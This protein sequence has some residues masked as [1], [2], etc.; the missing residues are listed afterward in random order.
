[1]PTPRTKTYPWGPGSG[2]PDILVSHPFRKEREKDGAP[3]IVVSDNAKERH[4]ARDEGANDLQAG[5]TAGRLLGAAADG[6]LHGDDLD[7]DVADFG[8]ESV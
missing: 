8:E 7:G 2:A 4:G 6:F 3:E 1:M 5:S